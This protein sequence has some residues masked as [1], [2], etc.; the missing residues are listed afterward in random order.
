MEFYFDV[1]G[2]LLDFETGFVELIRRDYVPDL[3]LDFVPNTWALTSEFQNLDLD[4][5][6][7]KFLKSEDFSNLRPIVNVKQFNQISLK[8]R[9][10]L[11]SNLPQTSKNKRLENLKKAGFLFED[12]YMAGHLNFGKRK[13]PTKSE[14]ISRIKTKNLGFV[15]LDDHPRNCEDVKGVF[16]ESMVYLMSRKHNEKYKSSSCIRVHTWDA[17]FLELIKNPSF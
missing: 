2:V 12:L 11:I 15:F 1:D 3:P 17:F 4:K 9:V 7:V 8:H 13:Y 16:S 14:V 5:I 6:W 10:N